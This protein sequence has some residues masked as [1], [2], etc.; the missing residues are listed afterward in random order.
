[1]MRW[2]YAITQPKMVAYS[3]SGSLRRIIAEKETVVHYVLV[4][5]ELEN[6][7]L[8]NRFWKQQTLVTF[9]Y[10]VWQRYFIWKAC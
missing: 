3:V 1:M 7:V 6:K 9:F 2:K 10:L 4:K 5:R 8:F